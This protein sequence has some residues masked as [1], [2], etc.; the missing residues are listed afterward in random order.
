MSI[1]S[2]ILG[3]LGMY[4]YLRRK[5]LEPPPQILQWENKLRGAFT[6]PP[7]GASLTPEAEVRPELLPAAQEL[8][9]VASGT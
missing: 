5:G 1:A 6:Q 7:P 4:V 3:A 9:E 2:L 8:E